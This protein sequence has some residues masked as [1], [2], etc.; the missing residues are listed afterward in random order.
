[1]VILVHPIPTASEVNGQNAVD[2]HLRPT[3]R[4]YLPR[5][6]GSA[7]KSESGV[8]ERIVLVLT[9]QAGRADVTTTAKKT[10]ETDIGTTDGAVL[11][12]RHRRNGPG[13]RVWNKLLRAL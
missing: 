5:K 6:N 10:T 1:M 13:A 11:R 12:T 7:R 4:N 2:V 8:Q 9:N 3:H